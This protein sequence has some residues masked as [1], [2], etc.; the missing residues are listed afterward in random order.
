MDKGTIVRG[1]LFILV[2][3][4]SFLASKGYKTLPIPNENQ[5]ALIITFCVSAYTFYKHNV[6]K[7]KA[8][9]IKTAVLKEAETVIEKVAEKQP[10]P[11]QPPVENKK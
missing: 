7:K 4:N 6:F 11:T 10:T 1:V 8:S 2:W 5:V 9:E 3:V